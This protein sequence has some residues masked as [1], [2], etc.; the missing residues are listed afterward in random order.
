MNG[1]ICDLCGAF[2]QSTSGAKGEEIYNLANVS[3]WVSF[4]KKDTRSNLD[5]CSR[6]EERCLS[7]LLTELVVNYGIEPMPP[8]TSP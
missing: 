3:A 6:C 7:E 1:Y 8:G 5:L 2:V 4:T